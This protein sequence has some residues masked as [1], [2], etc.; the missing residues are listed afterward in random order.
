MHGS[1]GGV[2]QDDG[3]TGV[4]YDVGSVDERFSQ[5]TDVRKARGKLYRLETVLMILVLAKLCGEDTPFAIADWAKNHEGQ[6]VELLQLK[7]S[8][9]PS[10]HTFRRILAQG[11]YEEE[12][13]RLVGDYNRSG[14]HGEVYALDGKALR[15]VRQKEEEGGDY[16]LR[17]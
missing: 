7:R 1:T 14:A 17:V 10:H 9:R 13:E 2:K 15:G 8:K 3:A 5:L 12:M 6:L 11:V 4:P 16:L